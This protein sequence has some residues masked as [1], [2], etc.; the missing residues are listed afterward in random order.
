MTIKQNDDSRITTPEFRVR[1]ANVFRKRATK[2]DDGNDIEGSEKYSLMMIFPEDSDLRKMKR[3]ARKVA[4]TKFGKGKR[5]VRYDPF[6]DGEEKEDL[7]GF[8]AGM[9]FAT[10]STQFQ[11]GVVDKFVDPIIDQED[12]YDGCWAIATV[13]CYTYNKKGNK[14]VA[15]GLNNVQKVKDDERLSSGNS[16][17]SDFDEY[18]D[19]EEEDD[20]DILR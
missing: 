5:G 7:D 10:A 11:P 19:G 17:A 20:D 13:H 18:D 15:F 6:R 14:G 8:E 12:F 1:F 2:D 9:Q 4:E 16:A 3:E